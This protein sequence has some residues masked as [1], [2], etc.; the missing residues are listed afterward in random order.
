MK[1]NKTIINSDMMEF[2]QRAP[3]WP[4]QKNQNH[5]HSYQEKERIKIWQALLEEIVVKKS[6][7]ETT[8][9]D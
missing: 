3:E 9:K 4:P 1:E 8:T 7:L 6:V 5:S 2:K